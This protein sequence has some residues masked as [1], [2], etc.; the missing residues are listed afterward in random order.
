M[1]LQPTPLQEFPDLAKAVGVGKLY[2]KR[3]DLNPSGS[4]K[5][6]G[7]WPYLD[8]L[9]AKGEHEFC[10]SSSGNLAISAACYAHRNTSIQFSFFL[11]STLSESKRERLDVFKSNN[12]K[13][14]YSK[15]AKTDA[16]RFSREKK[17][18][19]L[20]GSTDNGMLEGY[21]HLPRELIK[22]TKG[23]I[24]GMC[25]AISSGTMAVGLWL[26]FRF[27]DSDSRIPQLHIVQT[28]K[29]HPIAS[30]FD[31]N[32]T[33]TKVSLAT[34]IVDRVAH[35]K[36]Q[37]IQAVK[38]SRGGGWVVSDEEI[39]EALDLIRQYCRSEQRSPSTSVSPESVMSLAGLKKALA[40]GFQVREPVVLIF[41][42]K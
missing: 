3:E 25:M 11:P 4:H 40:K 29:I 39:K 32:F 35:R 8:A 13:A 17:I 15:T 14:Y 27:Q 9:V 24:G 38:E 7:L 6:R 42:G 41:S 1:N 23:D 12:T 16:I 36:A 37:V 2:I 19:L 30:E 22:Q 18:R 34:A 28:T 21:R 31:K 26:G 10:L 20:R 33:S 5:D